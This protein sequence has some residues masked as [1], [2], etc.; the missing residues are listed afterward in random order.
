MQWK[1]SKMLSSDGQSFMMHDMMSIKPKENIETFKKQGRM[2]ALKSFEQHSLGDFWIF[3]TF[4]PIIANF[5]RAHFQFWS[6][7]TC[8]FDHSFIPL[9]GY[10]YI[11]ST[12]IL[13]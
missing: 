9:N 7:K 5:I 10:D 11:L 4:E 13:I 12:K 8:L 3:L 2:K 1:R 6:F